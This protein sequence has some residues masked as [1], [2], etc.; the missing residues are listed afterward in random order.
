MFAFLFA[1]V[2]LAFALAKITG[3]LYWGFLIVAG[4]YLFIAFIVWSL[5][6]KILRLPLMNFMLEQLFKTDDNEKN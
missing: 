1:S 3:T 6:E 5:Q 4:I 2:A